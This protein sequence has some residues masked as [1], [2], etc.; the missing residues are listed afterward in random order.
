M[1][2]A[3]PFPETKADEAPQRKESMRTRALFSGL[4]IRTLVYLRIQARPATRE[5]ASR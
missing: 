4:P 3:Q 5:F 1:A 2:T